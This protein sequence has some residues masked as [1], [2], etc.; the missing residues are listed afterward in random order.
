MDAGAAFAG[1]DRRELEHVMAEADDRARNVGQR[2]RSSEQDLGGFPRTH[3][4]DQQLRS[5]EGKGANLFRDI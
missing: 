5:N 1:L 4:L 2:L 3:A